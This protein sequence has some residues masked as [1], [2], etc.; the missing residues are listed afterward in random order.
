MFAAF[1][2]LRL[3]AMAAARVRKT[4]GGRQFFQQIYSVVANCSNKTMVVRDVHR[5]AK[6]ANQMGKKK[7]NKQIVRTMPERSDWNR[8]TQISTCS[9]VR[10]CLSVS[11]S[12][13]RCVDWTRM[14][15][16]AAQARRCCTSN[17][18]CLRTGRTAKNIEFAGKYRLYL[19]WE[20]V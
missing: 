12:L 7:T 5:T 4:V 14:R 20:W 2:R 16:L 13:D 1:G 10:F 8:V 9:S 15:C 19:Q 3:D 11:A 17:W 18:E 6:C